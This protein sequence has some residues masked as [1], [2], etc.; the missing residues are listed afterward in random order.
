MLHTAFCAMVQVDALWDRTTSKLVDYSTL[1]FVLLLL[2][3]LVK[4]AVAL[5]AGNVELL[6][7]LAWAVR[8]ASCS[9]VHTCGYC[10]LYVSLLTTLPMTHR[11]FSPHS[12]RTHSFLGTFWT[13]VRGLQRA[14]K[15]SACSPT[16][17]CCSR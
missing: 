6:A 8:L 11:G 9:R 16:M 12:W 3:Q 5:R 7:G 13:K 15:Q 2:P 14:S 10:T 4:N 17:P 1:A